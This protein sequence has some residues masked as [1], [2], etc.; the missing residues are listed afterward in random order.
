MPKVAN[1]IS[2]H[3]TRGRYRARPRRNGGGSG[4]VSLSAVTF[5]NLTQI[6]QS[7]KQFHL[8]CFIRFN[9]YI[10]SFDRIAPGSDD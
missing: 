2:P 5:S 6:Q 9:F 4:L 1:E 10:A 3:Y 8:E 7:K